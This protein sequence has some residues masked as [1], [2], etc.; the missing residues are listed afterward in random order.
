ME[1]RAQNEITKC[2]FCFDRNY[3]EDK[4]VSERLAKMQLRDKPKIRS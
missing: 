1:V 3:E 2:S 4:R